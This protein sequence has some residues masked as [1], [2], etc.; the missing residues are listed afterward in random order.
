[1]KNE[2]AFPA[3]EMLRTWHN[4]ESIDPE[5]RLRNS[6]YEAVIQG[7]NYIVCVNPQVAEW[8]M[9][10]ENEIKAKGYIFHPSYYERFRRVL[11]SWE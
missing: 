1:M 4:K 10:H 2:A 8:A 3:A 6:L 5:V 11:I 7:Y 9:E